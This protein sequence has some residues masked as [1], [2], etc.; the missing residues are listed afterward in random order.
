MPIGAGRGANMAIG[1]SDC[2]AIRYDERAVARAADVDAIG[3]G[4][5]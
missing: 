2:A 3:V 4:P 1:A 5:G